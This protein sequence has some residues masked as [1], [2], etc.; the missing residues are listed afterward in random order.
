MTERTFD[1]IMAIKNSDLVWNKAVAKYMSEYTGAPEEEYTETLISDIL[2]DTVS[3]Y[4]STCDNP[5]AD[6]GFL[7]HLMSEATSKHSFGYSY[8]NFLGLT[9]VKENN[10]YINGFQEFMR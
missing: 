2:Q 7:L 10:E 3:D 5:G 9:R 6:V 4:I 1:I 8:A